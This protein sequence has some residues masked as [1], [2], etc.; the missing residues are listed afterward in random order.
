MFRLFREHFLM[1]MLLPDCKLLLLLLL[2][3]LQ[4]VLCIFYRSILCLRLSSCLMSCKKLRVDVF[5][6]IGILSRWLKA[7]FLLVFEE[8]F[9]G[10]IVLKL[11]GILIPILLAWTSPTVCCCSTV[12]TSVL[13]LFCNLIRLLVWGLAVSFTLA[14]PS[15][16]TLILP[17]VDIFRLYLPLLILGFKF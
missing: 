10:G 4:W 5:S 9:F 15:F 3:V 17:P 13:I 12:N 14:N 1:I 8:A 11:V 2:W 16:C 6:L 7:M